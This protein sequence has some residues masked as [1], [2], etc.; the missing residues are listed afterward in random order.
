MVTGSDTP[1]VVSKAYI[2]G[3]IV[4]CG[5]LFA[6]GLLLTGV[7]LFFSAY[8]PLGLSYQ[9]SFSHLSRLKHEMLLKSILIY[10]LLMVLIIVGVT[11]VSVLYSHRVVGPM[12]GLLRVVKLLAAGDFTNFVH[13]RTK[14]AIKPMAD[15]MNTM[16]T[17]YREKIQVLQVHTQN[18]Q[19]LVNQADSAELPAAMRQEVKAIDSIISTLKL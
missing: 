17:T 5:L 12:V 15:T 11:F 18:M 13:L 3:F 4:K 10:C 6:A 9:E 14:D 8:Q 2:T 16:I 19:R 7:I 1:Q